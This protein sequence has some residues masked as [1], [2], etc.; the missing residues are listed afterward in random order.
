LAGRLTTNALSYPTSTIQHPAITMLTTAVVQEI[1]R[2]IREG[3]LSQRQIAARL[4]VGRG[5]ISAIASGRRG[6]YGKD[7]RALHLP[8]RTS[9]PIRCPQCGYRVY[10]PC[11]I[12]R[13]REH[14]SRQLILQLL[15]ARRPQKAVSRRHLRA[16]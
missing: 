14:Q 15:A 2:L 16:S 10:L 3:E 9:R 8:V 12:C 4:C 11:L 7:P 6:L 13:V 1:D 5:T